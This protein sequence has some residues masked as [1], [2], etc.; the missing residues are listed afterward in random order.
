MTKTILITGANRGLGLALAKQYQADAWRVLATCR[1]PQA[2][3]EL[4]ALGLD[5]LELEV[6]SSA[7]IAA[8]KARLGDEPIDI[9][10]NNAGIYGPRGL[11]L[12]EL[13]KEVWL[14]V[15]AVNTIAPTLLTQAFAANVASSQDKLLVF[16]S[17]DMGSIQGSDGREY[18]YRSSKAALNMVVATLAKALEPQGIRA[19][20]ISPGWVRTD[21]GGEAAA[22]APEESAS[23]MKKVLDSLPHGQSG[24]F[25]KYDG[26]TV[27]W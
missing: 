13:S 26:S 21:M 24:A 4:K 9:L 22:L 3:A 7:S 16:M 25:L 15:L 11:E 8:L 23:S 18:I 14:E 20:A 1:E 17:S 10:F 2:A 19:L 27:A 12:A 6:T 5:P